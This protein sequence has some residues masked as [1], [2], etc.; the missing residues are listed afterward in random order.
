LLD[1]SDPALKEEMLRPLK[2]RLWG[3]AVKRTA[4]ER[5]QL[6][7]EQKAA[8]AKL[9]S[10]KVVN[11][12]QTSR[13]TH[14]KIQHGSDGSAQARTIIRCPVDGCPTD[15]KFRACLAKHIRDAHCLNK[16]T[17]IVDNTLLQTLCDKRGLT[18]P[19]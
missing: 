19:S 18:P 17:G 10:L 9:A 12:S 6:E 14:H 15:Y 7:A 11:H 3:T 8:L 2:R 4:A 13:S 1:L 5:A 16:R